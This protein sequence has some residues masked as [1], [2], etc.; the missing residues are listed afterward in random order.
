MR[1][2]T[3]QLLK[4]AKRWD[5]SQIQD[6]VTEYR[7]K[8]VDLW[9]DAPRDELLDA[10]S[11][12]ERTVARAERILENTNERERTLCHIGRMQGILQ[13]FKQLVREENK[14]AD[15]AE[16]MNRHDGNVDEIMQAVRGHE[17]RLDMRHA[18]LLWTTGLSEDDLSDAMGRILMS[19][20]V[21]C[22][23][24]GKDILYV[25]TRAGRRYCEK[26]WPREKT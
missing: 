9:T 1:I 18:E 25:L 4:S 10:I 17:G 8:C 5:S 24:M 23:R 11:I 3:D 19:G 12:L 7:N 6:Y 14:D 13:V 16:L 2:E 15:V 20:A 22:H 26:R 21:E